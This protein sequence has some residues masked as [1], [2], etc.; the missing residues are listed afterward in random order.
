M[1]K[2]NFIRL[3]ED[4]FRNNWDL[5]AYTNYGENVTLSYAD[6]AEKVARLHLL[7]EQ[8]GISRGDKIS[9]VGRNTSNWAI[10]YVAT[11]TYGA[12]IVPILQDFHANDILHIVNHSESRLLFT[13]DQI[14]ENI[15]E[16]K[17]FYTTGVFSLNDLTCISLIDQ[18]ERRKHAD[19][20]ADIDGNQEDSGSEEQT[21]SVIRPEDVT[22]ERIDELFRQKYPYGFN[23]DDVRYIDQPN[24]EI[25]S[26]NYTSGTTGFSKGVMT[27]GNALA[28]NIIYGIETK[29][30]QRGDS[31]VAFL[32][33][34]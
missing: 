17:L 13:A 1:I 11:V 30:F 29:L 32:P 2:E 15:E 27:S 7:F 10:V 25:V 31:C 14:W 21:F 12:V 33:L 18:N 16:E 3:F 22:S 5:P 23:R 26:I 34:A 6:V 4:S 24:T 9:L 8:C 19:L 20:L 28:G